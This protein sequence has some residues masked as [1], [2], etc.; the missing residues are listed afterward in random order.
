MCLEQYQSFFTLDRRVQWVPANSVLVPTISTQ[1]SNDVP[2]TVLI[3]YMFSL[4]KTLA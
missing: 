4:V 1:K 2:G 3:G